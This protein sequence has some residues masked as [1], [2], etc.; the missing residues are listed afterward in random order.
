MRFRTLNVT[1]LVR[2]TGDNCEK[3]GEVQIKFSG[4]IKGHMG[5]R[6]H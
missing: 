2:V 5:K 4:S 3:T 1:S 6:K